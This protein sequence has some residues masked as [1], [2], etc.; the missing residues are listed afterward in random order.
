MN[1]K[2]IILMLMFAGAWFGP[3]L[4]NEAAATCAPLLVK[5]QVE[6][7]KDEFT[8]AD[9]LSADTC[10]QLR[11]LAARASLGL[12]PHRGAV[13]VL[14]RSQV[15]N[16]LEGLATAHAASAETAGEVPWQIP[17]QIIVQ[18]GG[19]KKSCA[20]IADLARHS[21]SPAE[22]ERLPLES[23]NCAAARSIPEDAPLEISKT[24]WNRTLVRWEFSLRCTRAEDCVPF[25]VW[26]RSKS[27]ASIRGSESAGITLPA[28]R[29]F[30]DTSGARSPRLIRPGQTATLCWNEGGIRIV[31]P[32]TCL[33]G[34]MRGETVRV[35][36]KN[37][38]RILRAEILSD[39]SLRAGL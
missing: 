28:G 13:R 22:E 11:T 36:F 19:A 25:M 30:P 20:A 26:A 24:F 6:V 35:R 2:W 10:V 29:E 3:G 14:S 5:A 39:G 31:L 12:A 38:G 17:A 32:V 21:L 1:V 8:L 7:E 16:W 9:L 18:R 37:A 15:E 33:D 23:F 27:A 34:G 4:Q